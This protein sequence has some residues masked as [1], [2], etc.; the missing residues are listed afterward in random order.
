M[1]YKKI[2]VPT[3]FSAH[4]DHAVATALALAEKFD[5]GVHL[6]H[7]YGLEVPPSYIA[8]DATAFFNPQDILDPMRES[9]VEMIESQVKEATAQGVEV[10]GT[11]IMGHAS[12]VILDEAE[13]LPADLIIM[14]TRGLTGF[15]HA[16]LGSTAERVVRMAHCP[17]MTVKADDPDEDR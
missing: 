16:L 11:V 12:Q 5:A 6:V 9:A 14:G 8:G 7:A 1:Q 4:A 2:L 17:V 13:R 10:D 3:D 15:K